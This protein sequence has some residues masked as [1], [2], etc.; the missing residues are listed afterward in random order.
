MPKILFL[1]TSKAYLP[2]IEAYKK[3]FNDSSYECWDSKDIESLNINEF[4]ILWYFMGRS[5]LKTRQLI[6]HEYCSLSTG[7]YPELKNKIKRFI[8]IKPNMRLFLNEQVRHEMGFKDNIP[9]SL[10]D[11]G[12][13]KEFFQIKKNISFDFVYVGEINNGRTIENLLY[14]ACTK[15]KNKKFLFIGDVC[16]KIYKNYKVYDNLT[17]TGRI[18]YLEIPNELSKAEYGIN[19]V[20]N[21]YPYSIQTSTKLIEYCAAGLKVI[22]IPTE[23]CKAFEKSFNAQFYYLEDDFSNFVYNNINNY[24]YITPDVSK[25][26]WNIML[27]K[28]G[29][30]EKIDKVYY[31]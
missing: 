5:F 30:K 20:P 1:N 25:L 18:P 23:W 13:A 11:M 19:F 22:T 2:E 17:F 24:K 4:D 3:Y 12:V 10:R 6:I 26:E 14:N 16:T 21:K 29:L 7:I 31:G 28:M 9:S 8:N 15:M 27:K